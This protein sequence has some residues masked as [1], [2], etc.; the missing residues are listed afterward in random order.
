M[1]NKTLFDKIWESHIVH[2]RDDGTCLIY[3]DGLILRKANK[4]S[5]I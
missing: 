3:I 1:T 4:S 2:E 5:G